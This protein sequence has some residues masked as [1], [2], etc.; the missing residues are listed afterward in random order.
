[1]KYAKRLNAFCCGEILSGFTHIL[2]GYNTVA[3]ATPYPVP[4]KQFWRMWFDTAQDSTKIKPPPPPPPPPPP[5]KKKKK[6]QNTVWIFYG[7]YST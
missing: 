1:M 5:K 7:I 6:R 3:G 2:Q 4:L